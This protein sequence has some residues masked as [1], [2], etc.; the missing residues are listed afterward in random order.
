MMSNFQFLGLL[1]C[2]HAVSN[3]C[4]FESGPSCA[5]CFV[6]LWE[7]LRSREQKS[8]I[9]SKWGVIWD[10]EETDPVKFYHLLTL[11]WV[12]C[13]TTGAKTCGALNLGL[14]ASLK[15]ITVDVSE[16]GVR[17]THLLS[18]RSFSVLDLFYTSSTLSGRLLVTMSKVQTT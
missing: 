6:L 8:A 9:G 16:A 5:S 7:I 10:T 14:S 11:L 17:I 2:I 1:K 3:P 4:N 12:S 18:P 15:R 13:Q